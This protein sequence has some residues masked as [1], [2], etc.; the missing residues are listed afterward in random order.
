MIKI[1]KAQ[2][3]PVIGTGKPPGNWPPAKK[4]REGVFVIGFNPAIFVVIR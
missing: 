4:P 3:L 1:I 2:Y